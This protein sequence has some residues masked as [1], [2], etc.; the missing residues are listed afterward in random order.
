MFNKIKSIYRY[1]GGR[2]VDRVSKWVFISAV[3]LWG[4]APIAAIVGYEGLVIM[5]AVTQSGVIRYIL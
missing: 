3:T 5:A 4:P 1:V 2:V